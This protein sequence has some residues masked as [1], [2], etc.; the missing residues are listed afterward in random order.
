MRALRLH[1][2]EYRMMVLAM[3]LPYHGYSGRSDKLRTSYVQCSTPVVE[4]NAIV[5]LLTCVPH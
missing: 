4:S 1:G 2:R 5:S 3:Q